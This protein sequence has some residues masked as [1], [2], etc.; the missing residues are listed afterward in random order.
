MISVIIPYF[1]K[2]PGILAK[3]LASIAAQKSCPYDLSVIVV[4][5]E[6]P[7]PV[8]PELKEVE[9]LAFEVRTIQQANSGPAGARNT[10]LNHVLPGTRYI[11]FLDSDD[12]WLP[13]HLAR[14]VAALEAGHDFYFSDF[15]QLHQTEGAFARAG[16][17]NISQHPLLPQSA[18]DLHAYQGDMLNQIITGNVIGT[19]TV[20]YAYERFKHVRFNTKF[21][22]AGEDYL[23]WMDLVKQGAKIAFS[24]LPEVR[25][26]QGV[27]IYSGSNWGSPQFLSRTHHELNYRKE[28]LR[29]YDLTPVQRHFV[30]TCLQELRRAFIS[31]LVHRVRHLK[32]IPFGLLLRHLKS[33]PHTFLL[34]PSILS[35]LAFKKI[36]ALRGA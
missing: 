9:P 11:A 19:P 30:E 28:T 2:K 15:Y 4:D 31:D 36:N 18:P 3:S 20:V 5:D 22:A 34:M 14:A 32:T 21:T 29:L 13:D 8:G 23:F 33:D 24:S 1:Q 17:L 35:T 6:S 16:R 25:C 12:A 26:G 10:G 27:N 7:A